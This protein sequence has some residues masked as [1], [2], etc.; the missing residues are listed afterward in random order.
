MPAYFSD[1]SIQKNFEQKGTFSSRLYQTVGMNLMQAG[2]IVPGSNVEVRLPLFLWALLSRVNTR[3]KIPEEIKEMREELQGARDELAE[4]D[5]RMQNATKQRERVDVARHYTEAFEKIV[6]ANQQGNFSFTK[7]NIYSIINTVTLSLPNALLKAVNPR[8]KPTHP[9][10]YVRRSV[11]A[12]SF[13]ELVDV[14]NANHIADTLGF[15]ESERSIIA[16]GPN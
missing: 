11:A 7:H 3:D 8:W 9:K 16:R 2:E 4:L 12:K 14:E 1:R 15:D 13:L 6:E 10:S 5:N